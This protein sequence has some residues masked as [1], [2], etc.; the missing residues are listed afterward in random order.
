V[1]RN[2]VET[3]MGAVVIVVAA[4]FLFFAYTTTQGHAI[5]GYEVTAKFTRVDGLRDG[6][7]VRV[8]GVKVGSVISQSL[9]PKTFLAVVTLGIDPAIKLPTDTVAHITSSGLLGDQYVSLDPG[10]EDTL[11]KAGGEIEHTE[12]AM[13]LESLIGSYIFSQGSQ[14]KSDGGGAAPAPGAAK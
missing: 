14:Q 1:N 6:G 5:G 8:S 3:I 2:P 10:N 13:N 4:V 9:D 12:P 11:I 7:D